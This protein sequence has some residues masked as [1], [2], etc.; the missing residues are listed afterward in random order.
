MSACQPLCSDRLEQSFL[1][2]LFFLSPL[3]TWKLTWLT[4]ISSSDCCAVCRF[5]GG[6]TSYIFTQW[7]S[8][9]DSQNDEGAASSQ[10]LFIGKRRHS[11]VSKTSPP[12]RCRV[13]LSHCGK[14]FSATTSEHKG[15]F[16]KGLCSSRNA[17]KQSIYFNL[18]DLAVT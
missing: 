3:H 6:V 17:K 8:S 2:L 10:R 7:Q 14:Q 18:I 5:C 4:L 13:L 16:T 1:L 12:G 11:L 9:A 15:N